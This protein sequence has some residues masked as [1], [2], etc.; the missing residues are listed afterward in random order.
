MHR[1]EYVKMRADSEVYL[2]VFFV[3]GIFL[4]MSSLITLM[5]YGQIMRMKYM[6]SYDTK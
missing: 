6:I 5:V 4:G 1:A 2:G 3:L